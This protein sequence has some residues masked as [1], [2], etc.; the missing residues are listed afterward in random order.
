MLTD[1]LHI[2]EAAEHT[3][4]VADDTADTIGT[5]LDVLAHVGSSIVQLDVLGDTEGTAQ[6]EVV[7]VV[8]RV[9]LSS[10][11]VIVG[12][13]E[14]NVVLLGCVGD[15]HIVRLVETG[16]EHL[17]PLVALDGLEGASST[18]KVGYITAVVAGTVAVISLT[19]RSPDLVAVAVKAGLTE[20]GQSV[21]VVVTQYPV[22]ITG[23]EL[24]L[25]VGHIGHLVPAQVNTKLDIG[26]STG[27][28]L[29]GGDHD[30]AVGSL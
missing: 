1:V 9:E 6:V 29:L 16:A 14:T 24:A 8:V 2:G 26:A 28:T 12:V 18:V 4:V 5:V 13:R 15:G 10:L 7:L 21:G 22:V 27:S 30:N 17:V 11:Y 3:R 25:D 19:V 23:T 20:T